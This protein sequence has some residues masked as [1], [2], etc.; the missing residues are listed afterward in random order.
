MSE[1]WG[2]VRLRGGEGDEQR[3]DRQIKRQ[4]GEGGRGRGRMVNPMQSRE[5]ENGCG[6]K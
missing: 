5:G 2:A 4:D 6:S 1:V 3:G